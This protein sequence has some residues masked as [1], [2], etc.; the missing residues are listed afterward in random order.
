MRV[1]RGRR[2]GRRRNARPTGALLDITARKDALAEVTDF[3]FDVN[4]R[5]TLVREPLLDATTRRTR[6]TQYAF[7]PGGGERVTEAYGF[8][9]A[10]G[11]PLDAQLTVTE[12][13]ATDEQVKVTKAGTAGGGATWEYAFG[14][15]GLLATAKLPTQGV[16]SYGYD[17]LG[18]LSAVTPPGG[19]MAPESFAYDFL[20][21]L[22]QRTRGPFAKWAATWS[23]GE[24]AL[25]LPTAGSAGIITTLLDGHGRPSHVT[26]AR[27]PDSTGVG[28]S[29]KLLAYDGWGSLVSLTE[30]R[31]G[32]PDV[33]MHWAYNPSHQ[34]ASVTR[35]GTGT[36][37]TYD[38]STRQPRSMTSAGAGT[39]TY[40]YDAFDRL[41][42]VTAPLGTVGVT[43]EPGGAR[44]DVVSG[45]GLVQHFCHD[46]RG[47]LRKLV[48]LQP[49]G[50][51]SFDCADALPPTA[52]VAVEYGYDERGNRLRETRMQQ[53]LISERAFGYDLADRLTGEAVVGG[54]ARTWEPHPDGTRHVE[55]TYAS[56]PPSLSPPFGGTATSRHEYLYDTGGA[57]LHIADAINGG[58]YVADFTSDAAGRMTSETRGGVTKTYEWDADDRLINGTV[59]SVS[60][61]T[62]ARYTYDGLGMRRRAEVTPPAGPSHATVRSWSW[63]GAQGDALSAEAPANATAQLAVSVAGL[64][65]GQGSTRFAVDGVGS[66]VA[67]VDTQT[68]GVSRGSYDAWGVP[69]APPAATEASQAYAGQQHD[70]DLGLSYAQQRWMNP[71]VGGWLSPDP[72]FGQLDTPA[73]LSTFAY[74]NGNPTRFVDPMGLRADAAGEPCL[75]DEHCK[76]ARSHHVDLRQKC[77]GGDGDACVVLTS[78]DA[79]ALPFLWGVGEL[80]AVARAVAILWRPAVAL[81]AGI[82]LLS[83]TSDEPSGAGVV[84]PVTGLTF[85][86]FQGAY[87]CGED[88]SSGRPLSPTC[89]MTGL[90]VGGLGR[91]GWAMRAQRL[92]AEALYQAEQSAFRGVL[93]RENRLARMQY[94]FDFETLQ[95]SPA[96]QWAL[97]DAHMI[98]GMA[99]DEA[100]TAARRRLGE[101]IRKNIAPEFEDQ[102][103][104]FFLHGTTRQRARVFR[105]AA[106]RELF[107]TTQPKAAR[108]FGER[109]VERYGAHEIGEG[110]GEVGATIIALPRSV[111]RD[112]LQR[113]LVR[114][115]R[116]VPGL[117]EGVGPFSETVFEPGALE[118]LEKHAIFEEL[119][120]EYLP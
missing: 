119:P 116:P 68:Q 51:L 95:S 74:A 57:L 56:A 85:G 41:G 106:G 13:D 110:A 108:Y 91:A 2:V 79:L 38:A 72:V 102:P 1:E 45:G 55:R 61:V 53:G 113:K 59:S 46:I 11:I 70:A 40:T 75:D 15:R 8:V 71:A 82:S 94:A 26:Y 93:A 89:V 78:V 60:G 5:L 39:A 117:P 76:Y 112:L 43:W 22:A 66:V 24:Q 35:A 21:R 54:A 33:E 28:V 101:F 88:I 29:E 98:L 14:P 104:E 99:S 31:T 58:P 114:P 17:A 44:L 80:P 97:Q 6:S 83:R 92:E 81:W 34:L 69:A 111:Y 30:K 12:L 86:T 64:P 20:G 84:D 62:V 25:S 7:L 50:A 105:P 27:G 47:Q 48:S 118:T 65:V 107:T 109:T 96:R 42:S 63:A 67:R 9:D 36:T 32:Q 115:G 49:G 52:V 87:S 90:G 73:S 16:F 37:Y 23:D 4:G 103:F 3:T 120:A 18:R 77:A 100:A 19:G 10:N